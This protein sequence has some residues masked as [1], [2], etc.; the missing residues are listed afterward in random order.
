V[1]AHKRQVPAAD[2]VIHGAAADV[3]QTGDFA[4]CEQTARGG[5][6]PRTGS[7][8]WGWELC[9]RILSVH[10]HCH[11]V[12]RTARGGDLTCDS[13][14]RTNVLESSRKVFTVF[15]KG[16]IFRLQ[17]I[18]KKLP[19]EFPA[20]GC[21]IRP[22]RG[23]GGRC[24]SG[25]GHG[26]GQALLEASRE[27]PMPGLDGCL[28]LGLRQLPDIIPPGDYC[29]GREQAQGLGKRPVARCAKERSEDSW[30]EKSPKDRQLRRRR[31]P[32]G[33]RQR[34]CTRLGKAFDTVNIGSAQLHRSG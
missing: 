34:T 27:G 28:A 9:C 10:R 19:P 1:D 6:R 29:Q 18:R 31:L 17:A 22:I 20:A 11:S 16:V 26:A 15:K 14:Y 5:T 32:C 2:H 24:D 21:P 4:H 30:Q 12:H 13:L 25:A 3:Q 7:F 33:K 23:R 8:P